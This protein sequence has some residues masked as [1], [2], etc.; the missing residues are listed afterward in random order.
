MSWASLR[1]MEERI[2]ELEVRIA[3][4]DKLLADLDEVVRA[5]ARRIETLERE[6]HELKEAIAENPAPVGPIDEEPPHY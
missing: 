2:V 6:L 1:S 3:F 5:N 4:Q